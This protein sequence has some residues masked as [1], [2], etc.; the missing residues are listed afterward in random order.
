MRTLGERIDEFSR[1]RATRAMRGGQQIAA[2]IRGGV[3]AAGQI[4]RS[5]HER[6]RDPNHGST[7]GVQLLP[8]RT[9]GA[10]RSPL[11]SHTV[12]TDA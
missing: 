3:R 6:H 12:E 10:A 4:Q 2:D 5:R 7:G 9:R 11:P 1:Q 8:H